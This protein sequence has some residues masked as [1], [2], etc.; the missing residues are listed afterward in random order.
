MS[1]PYDNLKIKKNKLYTKLS[2]CLNFPKKDILK[3]HIK[4]TGKNV[5]G[6]FVSYCKMNISF[7]K[8]ENK[9]NCKIFI[10]KTII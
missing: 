6:H 8:T 5:Q 4:C 1:N 10:Y 9:Q 7:H 3:F 2:L